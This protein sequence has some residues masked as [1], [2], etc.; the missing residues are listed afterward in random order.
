MWETISFSAI[1]PAPLALS[2]AIPATATAAEPD[3]TIALMDCSA[4]A[5]IERS[6]AASMLLSLDLAPVVEA[7]PV[8]SG[9]TPIKFLAMEIPTETPAPATPPPPAATLSARTFASMAEV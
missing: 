4:L 8:P 1:A 3:R 2:A 6:P 7:S 5:V 9:R